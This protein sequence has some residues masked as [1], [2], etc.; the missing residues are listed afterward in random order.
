M[1]I[2]ILQMSQTLATYAE[3]RQSVISANI[4]N[5][6]T[7]GYQAQDIKPFGEVFQKPQATFR[8]RTTRPSHF[9]S[10]VQDLSPRSTFSDI[11]EKDPNGNTV[12][13][14]DQMAKAAE[15]R[16][17]HEMAL[18]IYQKSMNILRTSL[19]R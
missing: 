4:A 15:V 17:Q 18:G 3:R 8:M 19:G 6:D 13:L 9:Q 16:Q 11:S 5:A 10:P 1:K 7:P 14:P 2:D 12:S